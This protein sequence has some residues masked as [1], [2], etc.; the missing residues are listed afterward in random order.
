MRSHKNLN[1]P[2]L[3]AV[4][5]R[6][7]LCLFHC[8]IFLTLL[9]LTCSVGCGLL[10]HIWSSWKKRPDSLLSSAPGTCSQFPAHILCWPWLSFDPSLSLPNFSKQQKGFSRLTLITA[11]RK[12][13]GDYTAKKWYWLQ[14]PPPP[15]FFSLR[16]LLH[17]RFSCKMMFLLK[18]VFSRCV[19]PALLLLHPM[20]QCSLWSDE[21]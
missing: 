12:S 4:T 20:H 2:H 15:L 19:F 5:K 17:N 7:V 10:I 11:E 3:L 1:Q 9:L 13:Q 18:G 6:E 8:S 14:L 16:S 21:G